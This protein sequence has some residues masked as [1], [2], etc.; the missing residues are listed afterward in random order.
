MRDLGKRTLPAA[1]PSVT[2]ATG[3][4]WC[5]APTFNAQADTS[6]H[7]SSMLAVTRVSFNSGTV[8]IGTSATTI[9]SL[10]SLQPGTYHFRSLSS[11]VTVGSPT[12]QTSTLAFS[13]SATATFSMW[14]HALTGGITVGLTGSTTLGSAIGDFVGAAGGTVIYEGTL[15]VT[16]AGNLSVAATR[17]GGTSQTFSAGA[18]LRTERWA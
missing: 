1:A 7:P 6:G 12:H 17:T 2:V 5:T 15:F 4:V 8:V 13:G 16:V 14:G 11:F 18:F 9:V 10:S 3:D